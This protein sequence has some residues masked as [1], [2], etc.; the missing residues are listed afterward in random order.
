MGNPKNDSTTD[1][2]EWT[3]ILLEE[4]TEGEKMGGKGSN[5]GTH[6]PEAVKEAVCLPRAAAPG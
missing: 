3:R 2:Y 6:E 5:A 1:G 4:T